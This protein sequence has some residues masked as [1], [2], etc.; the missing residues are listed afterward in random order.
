M[1][2][3]IWSSHKTRKVY[4]ITNQMM[5]KNNPE[6]LKVIVPKLY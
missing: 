3:K 4:K 2:I 1:T 6:N 5:Q